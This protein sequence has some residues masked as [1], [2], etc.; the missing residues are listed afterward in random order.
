MMKPSACQFDLTMAC[1]AKFTAVLI[2]CLVAGCAPPPLRQDPGDAVRVAR[3]SL[4]SRTG[5]V[6]DERRYLPTGAARDVLVVVG[7]GFL[8]SQRQMT[9]LARALAASGLPTVTLDFCRAGVWRTS[10]VRNGFDM[11]RVADA[12]HARHVV[13][14]GF[15]AGGLAALIAARNDPRALGAVT[16]DLVDADAVG[17][18]AAVGFDRPL[19]GL[20][21]DPAACNARGNGLAVLA[22]APRARIERIPGADHCDFE[23]PTDRLCR[24]L[25]GSY[26]RVPITSGHIV[27]AS[28]AAVRSLVEL[29]SPGRG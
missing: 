25:C 7:H 4:I 27:R 14:V 2:A 16:L 12:L 10:H 18:H 20:V 8:R 21:G 15:S 28:V 11:L 29:N 5:C 13:Y 24:L 17:R 26:P 6:L 9:G 22:A 1:Q 19:I 3:G 23:S